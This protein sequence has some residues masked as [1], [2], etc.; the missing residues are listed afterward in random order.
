VASESVVRAAT[1]NGQGAAPPA[2]SDEQDNEQQG[3]LPPAA[4]DEQDNEQ[5]APPAASEE[6]DNEQQGAPAPA[7]ADEDQD[8]SGATEPPGEAGAADGADTNE[9]AEPNA[10]EQPGQAESPDAAEQPAEA[11]SPDAAE[12]SENA[13]TAQEVHEAKTYV[14]ES[15]EQLKEAIK[16]IPQEA[17]V[18]TL[19]IMEETAKE[20][21][22][23]SNPANYSNALTDLQNIQRIQNFSRAAG[24][25]EKVNVVV[26]VGTNLKSGYDSGT[27]INQALSDYQ[28]GK[29]DMPTLVQKVGPEPAKI[30]LGAMGVPYAE[31]VVELNVIA[32]DHALSAIMD[33]GFNKWDAYKGYNI[34]PPPPATKK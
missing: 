15:R 26:S 9:Q 11:E 12:A 25:L 22:N 32:V 31:Q 17:G 33:W 2:A 20:L 27:R 30:L 13:E 18:Q 1:G 29:I 4:S 7:A 6:Q 34:A 10:G 19:E 28:D 21:G 24:V 23:A 8:G 14:E 5:G 3:A 16:N